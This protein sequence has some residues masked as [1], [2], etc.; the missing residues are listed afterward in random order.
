MKKRR[1]LKF[2]KVPDKEKNEP[3][4]F[5]KWDGNDWWLRF[6]AWKKWEWLYNSP[7]LYPGIEIDK[8]EITEQEAFIEIL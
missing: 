3:P 2:Y 4:A 1:S 7:E 5:Y 8:Y 6:P